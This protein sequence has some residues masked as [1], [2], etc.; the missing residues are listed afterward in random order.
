MVT[1]HSAELQS[2]P[3]ISFVREKAGH[4]L[5]QL[6]ALRANRIV[7]VS[8]ELKNRLW[9][10]GKKVVVIPSSV[11]LEH[12]C[13]QPR[14]D[15]RAALGWGQDKRVVLFYKGRNQVTKRLDRALAT[16]DIARTILGPIEL[17]ILGF[18]EEPRRVPLYLNAADCLLCTS[19]AEGSPTIV[20]EAMACNL[21]VVSVDVGDVR[22]RLEG[23]VNSFIRERDPRDLA[24]ALVTVL[25]SGRRSNG[26]L[27]VGD[28]TNHVCRERLLEMYGTVLKDRPS[29]S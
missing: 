9:W 12:F 27:H 28:V 26:R 14:A 13:P 17:E 18:S 8:E 11:N 4:I 22:R 2:E 24:T 25:Q 5:S 6:A 10:S 21:P 7:C 20:K 15:A 16:L 3:G 23:V 19:D 29:S 1:F